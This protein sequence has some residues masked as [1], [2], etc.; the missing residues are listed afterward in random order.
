M[1][2]KEALGNILS[3]VNEK[4]LDKDFKF[5]NIDTKEEV[6]LSD[7]VHA[8][9]DELDILESLKPFF[10]KSIDILGYKYAFIDL[11]SSGLGKKAEDKLLK[12]LD[13]ID[14]SRNKKETK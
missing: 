9:V 13:W 10:M 2:S 11:C 6:T 3:I 14:E 1:T 8:I 5:I 4:C 12:W 7:C